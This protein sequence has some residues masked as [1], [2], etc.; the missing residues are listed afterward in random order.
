MKILGATK[1]ALRRAFK[2]VREGEIVEIGGRTFGEFVAGGVPE[3]F[4][5]FCSD[6]AW[7]L[8]P[9][10]KIEREQQALAKEC[11]PPAMLPPGDKSYRKRREG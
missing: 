4:A 9:T 3:S 1:K 10:T 6:I 7:G 8:R 11:C 5:E 2:L